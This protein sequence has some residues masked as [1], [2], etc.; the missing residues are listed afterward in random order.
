[1]CDAS[2][3]ASRDLV[4]QLAFAYLAGNGDVHAKNFS[5]LQDPIGEWQVSP[6]YD[7]PCSHRY[8]DTTMALSVGGRTGAEF[9]ADDLAGLGDTL[10]VPNAPRGAP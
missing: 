4:R 1:M 2:A 3:L 10:G 5:V 8:G 7:A 9:D 6:V